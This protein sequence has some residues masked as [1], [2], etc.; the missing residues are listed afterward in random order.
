MVNID[1][2]RISYCLLNREYVL[3]IVLSYVSTPMFTHLSAAET[4]VA[5]IVCI[6]QRRQ[7]KLRNS[8]YLPR[9]R[10]SNTST[11]SQCNVGRGTCFMVVAAVYV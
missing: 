10:A 5:D 2:H 4:S 11:S 3:D 6:L 7:M 9:V 1:N 8:D